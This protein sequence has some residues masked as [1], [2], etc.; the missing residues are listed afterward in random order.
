MSP[1]FRALLWALLVVVVAVFV[2]P[3]IDRLIRSLD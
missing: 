3:G 1:N 2:I